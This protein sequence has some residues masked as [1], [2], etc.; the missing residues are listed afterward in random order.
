[1]EQGGKW[2]HF[3]GIGG[4]GMSGLAKIMLELGHSVS[5]SDLRE[6]KVTRRLETLGAKVYKGHSR[7]NLDP[8]VQL[9]VISSAVPLDNEEVVAAKEKGIPVIQRG[10]LLAR[11]MKDQKGIAVAG[12]HG[13][14][15]TTSMISL[16]L[17]KNGLDP[18]VVIGGE[19]N[20][21]GGNAKLGHGD[22]LV[23]EADESDG[24]FLKLDPFV[25]IVTNIEDDHL[26]FYG[27]KK[28]L[29]EAFQKFVDKVP[30]DGLAVLCNDDPGVNLLN[31][32][33]HTNYITYG[34]KSRADYQARNIQQKRGT[35]TCQVFFNDKQLGQLELVVPGLHNI[36]NALATIAVAHHL[37][38][39]FE[40]ITSVLRDFK[41]VE[42]RFQQVG[43]ISDIRIIDDYAHHPT[44]LKA[45]LEAARQVH[46]GRIIAVFQPHRYSRTRQ[47]YQEFGAAF[48]NAD[49]VIICD[50]YSAG[51]VPLP[52]VSAQLIVEATRKNM[53]EE[54]VVYLPDLKQVVT[55]LER[56][57][58][59]GDM[60][61]TLGAGDVWKAGIE[62][63]EKLLEARTVS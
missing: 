9:V 28:K 17:E 45:T 62:L 59:S 41:G 30:R 63:K 8:G 42:R 36:N 61:I 24:S 48:R 11:L 33:N 40:Y 31:R 44:E 49:L 15:T 50:I 2:T 43:N 54:R 56:R 4:A 26:D 46:A 27:D 57:V 22:Y 58:K 55:Y 20:D 38:I 37:G 14:T 47:L 25:A 21:I 51:E 52:G 53:P 60:V 32:H 23:A 10:E 19:L 12:A 18:T 13:K 35:T 1:M 39:D 16:V 5:G 34:L 29:V 6:S 7:E 3:V